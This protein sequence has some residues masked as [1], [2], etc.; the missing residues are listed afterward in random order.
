MMLNQLVLRVPE[1]FKSSPRLPEGV[2]E[3]CA[4]HGHSDL[5]K[6][7]LEFNQKHNWEVFSNNRA[8]VSAAT[9][10][11]GGGGPGT[12]PPPRPAPRTMCR[13]IFTADDGPVSV[14]RELTNV[15]VEESVVLAKQFLVFSD[16]F[17]LIV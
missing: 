7:V 6:L 2:M 11:Y 10:N 15:S 13:P 4:S 12:P 8:V 17:S 1:W 14:N 16:N 3:A 9:V 5:Q